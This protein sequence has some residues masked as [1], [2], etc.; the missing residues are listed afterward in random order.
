MQLGSAHVVQVRFK[1]NEHALLQSIA[2]VRGM[3]TSDLVRELMGL[4]RVDEQRSA[5]RR[6]RLVSA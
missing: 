2:D 4:D 5:Q 6:L 3:T 1:A